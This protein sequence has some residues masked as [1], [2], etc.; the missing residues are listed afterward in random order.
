[1]MRDGCVLNLILG[2]GFVVLLISH[3]ILEEGMGS[4]A[5]PGGIHLEVYI[6]RG[7]EVCI[8]GHEVHAQ[9]L[10]GLVVIV[11]PAMSV[12]LTPVL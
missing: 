12:S 7:R 9:L 8:V 4:G 3:I 11:L 1:M 6:R 2:F 10:A 5:S